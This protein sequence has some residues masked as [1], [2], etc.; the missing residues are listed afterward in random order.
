MYVLLIF[1][2]LLLIDDK[3]S[4]DVTFQNTNKFQIVL[5]ITVHLS[6]F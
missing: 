2:Y 5:K 1:R 3:I 6:Y 4:N